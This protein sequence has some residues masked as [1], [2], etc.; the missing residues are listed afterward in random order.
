M[1]PLYDES[2]IRGK[3]PWATLFLIFFNVVIFFIF[4][5]NLDFFIENFGFISE[6]IFKR[7]AIFS[8]FSSM[9]LH[10]GLFHL[11]GNMWFLW[12]FGDN[13]ENKIGK[14]KF[15]IFYFL[16]GIGSALLYSITAVNK[17]IPVVGASGA[18]SGILGGYLILFPRN[19]IK[20]LVPMF[21]FYRVVT[22][23]ALIYIGIWFLYQ[24][25]YMGVDP[26]VAYWGHIG[27][28]LTGLLLINLFKKE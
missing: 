27:G 1:L 8:L 17:S 3:I 18:I 4:L 21:Y 14:I 26:F 11:F 20:A 5:S 15:L 22:I 13:L 16:C 25:L 7:E 10:G 23:P 2:R 9:F 24:F 19:Q 12:V 28:F 6:R